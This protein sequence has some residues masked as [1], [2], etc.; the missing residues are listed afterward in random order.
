MFKRV[1]ACSVLALP[2]IIYAGDWSSLSHSHLVSLATALSGSEPYVFR[3]D[4]NR[5]D[6][7]FKF[8][9]SQT[10][11]WWSGIEFS[12]LVVNGINITTLNPKTGSVIHTELSGSQLAAAGCSQP[13]YGSE[14]LQKTQ[15]RLVGH[16]EFNLSDELITNDLHCEWQTSSIDVTP[17]A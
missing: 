16:L 4:T 5:P 3:L 7:D 14:S 13:P 2:A 9:H 17:N 1:V 12:G 10:S 8:D 11:G 6:H 15:V